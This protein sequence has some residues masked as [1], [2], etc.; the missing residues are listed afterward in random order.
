MINNEICLQDNEA[1]VWSIDLFNHSFTVNKMVLSKKELK[2]SERF[3]HGK[4]KDTYLKCRYALRY[5]LA[6]YLNVEPSD[7]ELEYNQYGKPFLNPNKYNFTLHFNLS[8]CQNI[9]CIAITKNSII[10]VD[11][12]K[13]TSPLIDLTHTFLSEEE[14]DLLNS[15][16]HDKNFILYHL[17]V[18]KEAILKA[19]G[20]GLHIPPT[21][22]KGFVTPRA[23]LK[24]KL[25]DVFYVNTFHFH[26][27]V[28][29]ISTPSK[30]KVN[31]YRFPIGK[32]EDNLA[33]NPIEH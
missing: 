3:L 18:Q 27:N 9:A 22:V 33:E 26:T 10:G 14:I 2:R 11:V 25:N 15:F 1:H 16:Q 28:L 6:Y 21:E 32:K 24:N 13:V 4:T 30:V 5:L 17:W 23:N 7:I 31:F 19:K 12:E 8:H 20:T 29:A